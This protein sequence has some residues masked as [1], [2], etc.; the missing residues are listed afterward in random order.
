[1][2]ARLRKKLKFSNA[3]YF[4]DIEPMAN[5]ILDSDSADWTHLKS[6]W[7]IA[8]EDY[9]GSVANVEST[10]PFPGQAFAV[11]GHVSRL[12]WVLFFV[13]SR[14]QSTLC[15]DELI[16]SCLQEFDPS[17]A[18]ELKRDIGELLK[19]LSF[20]ACEALIRIKNLKKATL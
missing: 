9:H 16:E 13:V 12:G 20:S 7:Q 14:Q 4:L 8:I 2:G 11:Y 18:A 17:L 19:L 3:D 6:R 10:T 15:A 1:L 5:G